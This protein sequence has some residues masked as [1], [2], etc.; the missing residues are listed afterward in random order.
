MKALVLSVIA[1]ATVAGGCQQPTM[2]VNSHHLSDA[3]ETWVWFESNSRKLEGVWHCTKR[4]EL[5]PPICEKA[6]LKSA[7]KWMPGTPSGAT[8]GPAPASRGDGR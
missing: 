1:T 5:K 6:R 8:R 3:P 2:Y 4:T 7:E